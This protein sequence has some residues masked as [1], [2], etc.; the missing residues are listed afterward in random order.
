[1]QI[2]PNDYWREQKKNIGIKNFIKEKTPNTVR[3]FKDKINYKDF[4]YDENLIKDKRIHQGCGKQEKA[5]IRNFR[6]R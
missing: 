6:N 4:P 5:L 3:F 2:F 1:M